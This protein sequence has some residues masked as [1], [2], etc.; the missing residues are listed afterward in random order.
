MEEVA[1][2]V[3]NPHAGNRARS[4]T[5]CVNSLLDVLKADFRFA[6]ANVFE[7]AA[8]ITFLSSRL[9]GLGADFEGKPLQTE[10]PEA[11]PIPFAVLPLLK[12][13]ALLRKILFR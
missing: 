11:V 10:P 6:R 2:R 12:L 8:G 7:V 13:Y 9:G 1:W 4:Q 3:S 5:R